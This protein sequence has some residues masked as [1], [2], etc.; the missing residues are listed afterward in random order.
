MKLKTLAVVTAILL[1]LSILVFMNENKRGTD[2]IAGSDYIKGLDI[3]KLQKIELSFSE[4]KKITLT[5]DSDKYIL[6]NHKSY[7]A[8]TDKVNDLIFKIASIQV[9]EKVAASLTEEELTKYGLDE[10]KSQYRVELFDKEGKKAVSFRVG[11]SIKGKGNYLFKEGGK[12]EVYI[13]KESVWINSSYKDFIDTVLFDLKKDQIK[14]VQL[15]LDKPIKIEKKQ[16]EFVVEGPEGTKFK[17]EKVDQ[18]AESFSSIRF[19]DYF[20]YNDDTV[21]SITYDHD[22]KVKLLN[23]LVY[24]VSLAKKQDDYFVKLAAVAED[25]PEKIMVKKDDGKKELKKIEDIIS[26]QQK[27]QKINLEKGGW[28]Y[29]VDKSVYDKLAV[30]IKFFL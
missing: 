19:L 18:F 29:K 16:D 21:R 27:A 1:V 5:R 23:N 20:S 30:D 24:Q 28:V 12:N 8:A 25:V 11:N 15:I 4:G 10:K 9:K 22:I 26:A 17:K 3:G 7:P 2:L 13:S 6:E 14:S